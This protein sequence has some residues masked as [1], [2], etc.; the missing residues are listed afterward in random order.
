MQ[1]LR[2]II[3][4]LSLVGIGILS[5]LSFG[6]R[7]TIGPYLQLQT[8][9]SMNI[10]W[11]TD[12]ESTG[13]IEWGIDTIVRL[14]K[15]ITAASTFRHEVELSKLQPDTQYYYR[16]NE[17]D[18]P[19]TVFIPFRTAPN[20]MATKIS[21]T[22][23]GD[24]RS[25]P[26]VC[27]QVFDAML[28]QTQQG[29]CISLGDLP[30]RG[31]D[32]KTDY[33][34]SHFFKPAEEYISQVCLYPCMA[35][36]ELYNSK[37]KFVYPARYLE[38]WSLPT[39]SSGTELYYSF[40]KGAVHFVSL[41]VFW[42]SYTTGSEQYNWLQQDLANTNKPWKIVFMH[43]GPYI[44]QKSTDTGGMIIRRELVPIFEKYQVDMVTYG[45]YH[46]Y[47]RNLVNGITYLVQ[48]TGGAE[49]GNG[50]G[51][52][53]Y[54]Q[55]FANEFSFTRIDLDNDILQGSTYRLDGSVIDSFKIKKR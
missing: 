36:H 37:A 40:D 30:G 32:E 54:V 23:Q 17:P 6:A 50:D 3:L 12:Q 10:V 19:L 46:I 48:G 1:N 25:N 31:E 18:V 13:E 5:S 21:F 27:K 39:T 53:P 26:K 9:T 52:Q 28:P 2:K 44:S 15:Y 20:D 33:W 14:N 43:N 35:N 22:I 55:S 42:S 41:D 7:I 34:L 38:V 49:L 29:F 24:S 45:H 8:A 51:S 4:G 47:Q 11:Y 16:V